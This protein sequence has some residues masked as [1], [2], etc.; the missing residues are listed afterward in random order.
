MMSPLKLFYQIFLMPLSSSCASARARIYSND[1]HVETHGEGLGIVHGGRL[2]K[3]R[4]GTFASAN[5]RATRGDQIP[6]PLRLHRAL[7]QR[8]AGHRSIPAMS[9]EE[10]VEP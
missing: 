8:P 10:H 1:Q 9:A 2:C 7:L 6:M 3:R 5:R 4:T